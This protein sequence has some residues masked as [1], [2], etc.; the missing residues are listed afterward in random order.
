[1]FNTNSVKNQKI[2]QKKMPSETTI[3]GLRYYILYYLFIACFD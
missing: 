1:M 2:M 3:N